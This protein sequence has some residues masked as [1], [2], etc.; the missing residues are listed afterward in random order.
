MKTAKLL[1][2]IRRSNRSRVSDDGLRPAARAR[3]GSKGPFEGPFPSRV[4]TLLPVVG[5]LSFAVAFVGTAERSAFSATVTSVPCA[6]KAKAVIANTSQS[7]HNAASAVTGDVQAAQQIVHNGGTISGTQTPNTPANLPVVPAPAGA[8]NLGDFSLGSGQTRNLAAGNYVARSFNLNSNSTL[9]V[10]G[11]IVQIWV[12]GSL[13]IGGNANNGGVPENLE[14][15]V[16][17]VS[18]ANVNG[19]AAVSALIYA[20]TGPVT[21]GAVVHG[22]VTGSRTTLNSGGQ[23]VFDATSICPAP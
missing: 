13:S 11:G 10:S 5:A 14:F 20:P 22:S 19:G 7:F 21:V 8:T 2:S 12:T 6:A 1:S 23:V 16:S 18:G 9:T 15:L 17:S 4:W 3:G